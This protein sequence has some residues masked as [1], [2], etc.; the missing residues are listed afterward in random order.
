MTFLA[1]TLGVSPALADSPH[2]I[3]EPTCTPKAITQAGAT[4]TCSGKA[5]GLGT[6]PAT[7]FLT[8]DQVRVQYICVNRGGNTAPGHPSFFGPVTGATQ[9]IPTR[10]GQITFNVSLSTPPTP[11]ASQVCPNGNWR[12]QVVSA[13]F[14]NVVLH[15]QQPAG[16][17]ILTWFFHDIDPS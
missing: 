6:G 17:D 4:I 2:F 12:V 7:A 16:T 1:L 9:N 14:V 10:Q 15:L 3:G 8:A 13:T 11:P 5:A